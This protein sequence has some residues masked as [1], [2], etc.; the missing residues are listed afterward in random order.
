MQLC[1]ADVTSMM[2]TVRLILTVF[3]LR[4]RSAVHTGEMH[5]LN[6]WVLVRAS[7]WSGFKWVW[8]TALVISVL[9]FPLLLFCTLPLF[10]SWPG[11]GQVL[12][13]PTSPLQVLLWMEQWRSLSLS[14]LYSYLYCALSSW[15]SWKCASQDW[16]IKK[17]NKT[18]QKK[19]CFDLSAKNIMHFTLGRWLCFVGCLTFTMCRMM[20]VQSVNSLT[21][22]NKV[23]LW[24]NSRQLVSRELNIQRVWNFQWGTI[25]IPISVFLYCV[26]KTLPEGIF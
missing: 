20:L 3:Q 10:G 6:R 7:C 2:Y 13:C 25:I 8:V 22:T 14:L 4:A 18:K 19:S 9:S 23:I 21:C 15:P 1:Q 17:I 11:A 26:F 12:S 5:C 24:H 16:E